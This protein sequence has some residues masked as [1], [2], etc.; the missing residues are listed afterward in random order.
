M[1]IIRSRTTPAAPAPA[2]KPAAS[3]GTDKGAATE[4][5]A[6][7][8]EPK[9]FVTPVIDFSGAKQNPVAEIKA[10]PKPAIMP[11]NWPK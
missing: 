10:G 4:K 7:S 2:A 1:G 6:M 11:A 8:T 5:K 3:N 9:P